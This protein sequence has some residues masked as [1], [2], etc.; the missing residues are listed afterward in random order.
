NGVSVGVGPITMPEYLD[1]AEIVTRNGPTSLNIDNLARWG[2]SLTNNFQM[3]LGE[4][5]STHLGTDR[6]HLYPWT[7][8]D[9]LRYQ[10]AVQVNAFEARANGQ[11]VLDTRWTVLNP[12]SNGVIRM[13]RS[14]LTE[15]LPQAADGTPDYAEISTA[16]SRLTDR[17][18]SE[19][20]ASGIR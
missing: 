3:V 8:S 2:G 9:T 1:R 12:E 16:M 11:V 7:T 6:I 18:G 4:S 10:I 14:V 17:L 5:L 20:A 15:T 19:I 13:G